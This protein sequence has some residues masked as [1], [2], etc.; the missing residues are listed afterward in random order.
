MRNQCPVCGSEKVTETSITE[1][2][3]YNGHNKTIENYT[4]TQCD[5]CEEEIVPPQTMKM[6]EKILRDFK[7]EVDGLLT[8]K[9]IKKIRTEYGFNQ[10]NFSTFLE[11]GTKT[12][13]R[14]EN[15]TVTQSKPMD[16]LLRVIDAIPEALNVISGTWV[17][18]QN[19]IFTQPKNEYQVPADEA[20]TYKYQV[21]QNG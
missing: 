9:E 10:E 17:P 19:Y 3:K 20:I 8:S 11:V 13:T 1:T 2:F 4:I 12:F 7:R 15:C 6:A 14:Y 5:D 21:A 16:L 18:E